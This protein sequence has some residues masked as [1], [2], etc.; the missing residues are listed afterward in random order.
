MLALQLLHN[1]AVSKSHAAP[2]IMKSSPVSIRGLAVFFFVLEALPPRS[3]RKATSS[4][5]FTVGM[6][7]TTLE[8]RFLRAATH[9]RVQRAFLSD[10][11]GAS[12]LVDVDGAH[13][14]APGKASWAETAKR[15]LSP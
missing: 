4:C 3:M 7:W 14:N 2:E 9:G 10:R 1:P 13:P 5:R 12:A 15:I 6:D 11:V 8:P